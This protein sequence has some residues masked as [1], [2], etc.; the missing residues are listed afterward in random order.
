M[1]VVPVP[2]RLAT[3]SARYAR[4]GA[5]PNLGRQMNSHHA[6]EAVLILRHPLWQDDH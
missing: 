5:R 1:W 2:D 4:E 3:Q 6:P